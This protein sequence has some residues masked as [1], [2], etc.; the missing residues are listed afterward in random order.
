MGGLLTLA[1][2]A[3]L[4]LAAHTGELA[5]AAAVALAQVL[6]AS[7]VFAGQA[8]HSARVAAGV[9]I[10][11]GFL[12]TVLTLWPQAIGGGDGA[13]TL[14][15]L[16]PAAAAVMLTAL[17]AQMARRGGRPGLTT[18]L[19][20]TVTLGV[21]ATMLA[22]WV[23]AARL[24]GSSE[25]V[26]VGAAAVAVTSLGLSL[27]GPSVPVGIAA[28]LAG[29]GA[30]TALCLQLAN[31][32]AW[33]FGAALGLTAALLTLAGRQLGAAWSPSRAHRVPVEAIAPL[34]LVGPVIVI[35]SQ[36]FVH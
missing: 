30:A 8:V 10:A 20:L 19:A 25:L 14:A 26:T 31:A 24:P 18:A 21:L 22:A 7:S 5:V 6:L 9:V 11:G 17:L 33:E 28:V 34:A 13:A 16:A 23:A 4:A 3:A 2:G 36:L 12:A 1:L 15:G 29:T 32:P 27:P 35:A